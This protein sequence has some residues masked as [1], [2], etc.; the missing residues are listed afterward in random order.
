L[1][2]LSVV[3]VHTLEQHCSLPEH[4]RPHAPQCPTL[5]AR[6]T[7]SPE[8]QRRL[9]VHGADDPHRHAPATHVSPMPQAGEQGTS[10]VHDP[11]R[12]TCAPVHAVPH[13]PQC[14]VLVL[15][16]THAAPQHAWPAAHAAPA[17]HWQTPSTQLSPVAHAGLHAGATQAP[18]THS[19][20]VAQ[21]VPHPPHAIASVCVSAQR[22]S[23]Q[24]VPVAHGSA[25]PQ[26]HVPTEH[27]LP[28]PSQTAPHAP[29]S[30][31]ELS[32][33]TQPPPQHVRPPSQG[34]SGEHCATHVV[35]R[36]TVPAGHA[37]GQRSPPA[38]SRGD[39]PS[40]GVRAS[41]P[42]ST[43]ASGSPPPRAQPVASAIT[44]RKSRRW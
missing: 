12:Q 42:G 17:P 7:H 20:P 10:V 6:F 31:S 29:Q 26:R 37:E 14:A 41:K 4:T 36:Q 22:A 33:L 32:V 25:A 23:Q 19:S 3:L 1:S 16:S 15:V 30:L 44:E 2:T 43:P 9:A 21:R 8:Q 38:S 35:P 27:T 18:A 24:S 13:A 34:S 28:R 39:V 40:I 11:L 5:V